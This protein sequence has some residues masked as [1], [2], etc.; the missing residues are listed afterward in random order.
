[1]VI[2]T[3]SVSVSNDTVKLA[4]G[5]GKTDNVVEIILSHPLELASTIVSL[6][7]PDSV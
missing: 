5:F 2:V 3:I 7:V 4:I 1:L 6:Y